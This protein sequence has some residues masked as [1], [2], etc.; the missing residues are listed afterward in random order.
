[1]NDNDT[2]NKNFHLATLTMEIKIPQEDWV[3]YLT[4][5][6]EIF[7]S[8][9]CGYW[10][11]GVDHD[12]Y[13]GWLIWEDDEKRPHG[14]EPNR[15]EAIQAFREHN[16]TLPKNWFVLNKEMAVKAYLEGVKRWGQTWFDLGGDHNDSMGYDT[17]IQLA[18]LGE[19]KYG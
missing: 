7:N 6:S 15:E 11:R 3:D 10:A 12:P 8:N 4:Q 14:E 5:D 1:M 16:T 13:I 17:V 9:Y 2:E 19:V 18:L